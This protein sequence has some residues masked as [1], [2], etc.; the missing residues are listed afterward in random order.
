MQ[1][2]QRLRRLRVQKQKAKKVDLFVATKEDLLLTAARPFEYLAGQ[3]FERLIGWT[4]SFDV[5]A[6]RGMWICQDFSLVWH[7]CAPCGTSGLLL[8]T[9]RTVS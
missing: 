9:V 7:S 2:G 1:T 4:R 3:G 8:G 6:I 5:A